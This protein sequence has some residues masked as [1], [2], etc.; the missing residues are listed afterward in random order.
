VS[1]D[2]IR[3]QYYR[4]AAVAYA[5]AIT[6]GSLQPRRFR[7]ISHQS[8][9]HPL[10]HVFIFGTLC[11]LATKGFAGKRAG[12]WIALGCFLLGLGIETAQHL[13]GMQPQQMEWNDVAD[14]GIGIG[15]AVWLVRAVGVARNQ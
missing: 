2:S 3:G 14:D 10:F 5:V 15:L 1:R 4:L 12:L 13:I 6:I 7:S 8:P 11:V 9:L